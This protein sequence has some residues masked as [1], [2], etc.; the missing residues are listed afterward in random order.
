MAA[1]LLG[2]RGRLPAR[3]WGVLPAL[4]PRRT[5]LCSCSGQRALGAYLGAV[6]PGRPD[7]PWL[8]S[9]CCRRTSRWPLSGCCWCPCCLGCLV[10]CLDV[11]GGVQ[12]SH[13]SMAVRC[14]CPPCGLPGAPVV[15]DHQGQLDCRIGLWSMLAGPWVGCCP[16]ITAE[17]CGSMLKRPTMG[18]SHLLSGSCRAGALRGGGLD[19]NSPEIAFPTQGHRA[20]SAPADL[21][22][23]LSENGRPRPVCKACRP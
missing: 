8:A 5:M 1:A 4:W 3:A 16:N 21:G 22:R 11:R 7:V 2:L 13:C 14:P 20:A 9:C 10:A 6:C 17:W 23:Q 15:V 19:C 12:R 18:V